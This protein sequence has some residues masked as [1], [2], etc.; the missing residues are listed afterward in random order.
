MRPRSIVFHPISVLIFSLLGALLYAVW[1]TWRFSGGDLSSHYLYVV[2]IVVP[3][4][5]FLFDRAREICQNH[6]RERVAVNFGVVN[7][8]GTRP[9]AYAG[10]SDYSL[11]TL[12][13]DALVVGTA[14]LRMAGKVPFVSGHALFLVYAILRPGSKV[15]R[16]TAG[17]V[18]LEVIYLKFFVWHDLITPVTGAALAVVAALITRQSERNSRKG[19]IRP[20]SSS[21]G[22]E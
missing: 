6:L 14:L 8:Q 3:F 17:I 21:T 9:P 11:T 1:I 15:T 19:N 10:G 16:I 12:V 4:V 20:A 2:P 13:I 7:R 18:M 22:N 5:A